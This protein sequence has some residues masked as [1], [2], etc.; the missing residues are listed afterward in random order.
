[1]LALIV[2]LVLFVIHVYVP[3][4][5]TYPILCHQVMLLLR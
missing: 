5:V 4:H 3:R 1:M 2:F